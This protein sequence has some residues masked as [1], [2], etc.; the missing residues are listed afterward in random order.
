M[1]FKSTLSHSIA[2]YKGTMSLLIL[3]LAVAIVPS[4]ISAAFSIGEVFFKILSYALGAALFFGAVLLFIAG[5]A[6]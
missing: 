4:A 5:L 2:K 6:K 3:L 1:A